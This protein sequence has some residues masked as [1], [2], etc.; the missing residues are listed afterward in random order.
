MALL[1]FLLLRGRC[2]WRANPAAWA[3]PRPRGPQVTGLGG[4]PG[5]RRF[6]ALFC[7]YSAPVAQ[8]C[9]PY[10]LCIRCAVCR[11]AVA[12]AG[13]DQRLSARG[14]ERGR[15]CAAFGARRAPLR[16]TAPG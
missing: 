1:R 12:E 4:R 2:G 8:G 15:S 16:S 14:A 6:A 7:F 9:R 13:V 3:G 5:E 10:E 11:R